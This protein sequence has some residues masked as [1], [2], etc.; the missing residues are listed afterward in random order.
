MGKVYITPR[1][2]PIFTLIP[3]AQVGGDIFDHEITVVLSEF[4][5]LRPT[6]TDIVITSP[7]DL[8]AAISLGETTEILVLEIGVTVVGGAAS[9]PK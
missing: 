1:A 8:F 3:N 4:E 5:V 7:G 9:I 6:V 2:P